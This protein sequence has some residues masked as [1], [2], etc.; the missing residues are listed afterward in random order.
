[1]QLINSHLDFLS[2]ENDEIFCPSHHESHELVTQKLFDLVSLFDGDGDP[3][4]VDG[5]FDQNAFLLVSGNDHR[6]EDQLGRLLDLDFWLVVSLHL[7]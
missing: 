7:L 1:M 6:I 3:N 5:R 4:G 2:S